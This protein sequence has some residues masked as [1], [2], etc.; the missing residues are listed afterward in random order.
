M[1]A[2]PL[3]S[4]F[5]DCGDL[6]HWDH[7]QRAQPLSRALPTNFNRNRDGTAYYQNAPPTWLVRRQPALG[8]RGS[9]LVVLA[10]P[11]I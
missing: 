11:G 8:L 6:G 7:G 9:T 4:R 10:L 3:G 1:Q 5:P 2:H